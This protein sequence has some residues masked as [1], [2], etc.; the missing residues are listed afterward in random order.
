[1]VDISI[2]DGGYKLTY[3]W[4]VPHC[5]GH[6]TLANQAFHSGDTPSSLDGLFHGESHSLMDDLWVLLDTSK[7]SL[8]IYI[9]KYVYWTLI[10]QI[11]DLY[12]I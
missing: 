5:R 1:M 12:S 8:Y 4:G 7:Y 11:Y 3:N 2:V 9:Y 10:S 6:F